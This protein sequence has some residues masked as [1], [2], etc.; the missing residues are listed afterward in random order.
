M[1]ILGVSAFYHDAAVALVRDGVVVAAAQQERFTRIKN[2]AN[3][4][5]EAMRYCL[6][7]G[8]VT[9]D[10]VHAVVY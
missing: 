3:F 2:D 6:E 10:G 7:Q 5:V 9:R 1:D 8:G 4:P